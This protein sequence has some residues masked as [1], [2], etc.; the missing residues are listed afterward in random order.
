MV[1]YTIGHGTRPLDELV[2]M[3]A[4]AGVHGAGP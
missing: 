1:V 4:A 2:A 3:L